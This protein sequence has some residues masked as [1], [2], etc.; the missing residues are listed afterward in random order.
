MISFTGGKV[1]VI[2]AWPP[3]LKPTRTWGSWKCRLRQDEQV[4]LDHAGQV[5]FL[6]KNTA[7]TL[8]I[9]PHFFTSTA[10]PTLAPET[11]IQFSHLSLKLLVSFYS[12][13]NIFIS[14]VC[15]QTTHKIFSTPHSTTTH[16]PTTTN[17]LPF[18]KQTLTTTLSTIN[19]NEAQY[20]QPSKP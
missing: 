7:A 1:P 11:F 5:N 16:L 15:I 20:Q 10:T 18:N 19:H 2:Q 12:F 3:T 13:L 9:S 14:T 8:P 4:N 17:H 6:H